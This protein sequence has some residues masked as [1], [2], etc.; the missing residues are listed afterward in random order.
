[1]NPGGRS[2][3]TRS[4]TRGIRPTTPTHSACSVLHAQTNCTRVSVCCARF[5]FT[6]RYR[7]RCGCRIHMRAQIRN[8]KC[9]DSKQFLYL[10]QSARLLYSEINCGLRMISLSRVTQ[11]HGSREKAMNRN[12]ASM[13]GVKDRC[14]IS[15]RA[16]AL[17]HRLGRVASEGGEG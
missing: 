10:R 9:K 11:R 6:Q 12:T 4:P 15:G 8:R 14:V 3:L 13:S 17:P 5:S 2:N 16:K 1:M 7:C